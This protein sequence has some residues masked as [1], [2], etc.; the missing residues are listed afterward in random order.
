VICV[1]SRVKEGIIGHFKAKREVR[2]MREREKER[3]RE[4]REIEREREREKEREREERERKKREKEQR[5]KER[6]RDIKRERGKR[7]RERKRDREER[8]SGKMFEDIK[9]LG[10]ELGLQFGR[11]FKELTW[12][13][14]LDKLFFAT[15]I[16]P[17]KLGVYVQ[18]VVVDR[19]LAKFGTL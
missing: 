10:P 14:L 15:P 9:K 7:E 11:A 17:L 19:T 16:L 5:R 13:P 3:K 1:G 2:K 12:L 4:E 18:S 6:E 8:C